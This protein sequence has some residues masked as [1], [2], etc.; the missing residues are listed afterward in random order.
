M[1]KEADVPAQQDGEPKREPAV[2]TPTRVSL[3][4][5]EKGLVAFFNTKLGILVLSTMIIPAIAGLYAHM[6]Q[7]A[8]QRTAENQQIIKLMAEF[9][10]RMAEIERFRNKIP[11]GADPVKYQSGAYIWRAII[12]DTAYIPTLPEFRGVHLGGIVGQLR[13]LGFEDGSDNALKA[14]KEMESGNEVVRLPSQP[15]QYDH[16]YDVRQL[17]AQ[18]SILKRFRS[19]IAPRTDF[20]SLLF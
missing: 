15:P 20:W 5:H 7:R 2:A 4:T 3:R 9:D 18:L 8:T 10:W 1:A 14:V 13:A 16:T 17:D 19:H 12:G 6:Q 11:N